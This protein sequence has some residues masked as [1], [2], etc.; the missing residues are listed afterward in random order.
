MK[1]KDKAYLNSFR[2]CQCLACCLTGEYCDTSTVVAH[3]V[4]GKT[5]DDL[6]IPL[7]YAHHTGGHGVHFVGSKVWHNKYLSKKECI[8]LAEFAYA[9]WVA[10]HINLFSLENISEILDLYFDKPL[11]I[12]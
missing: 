11:K 12:R 10:H 1:L 3:H 5:R 2:D 6:T 9:F 4:I 8:E 7:C